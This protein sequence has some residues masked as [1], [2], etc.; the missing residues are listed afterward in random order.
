[1]TN[2]TIHMTRNDFIRT[3]QGNGFVVYAQDGA[4]PEWAVALRTVVKA[5]LPNGNDLTETEVVHWTH[6]E[7]WRGDKANTGLVEY[8][9]SLLP[10]K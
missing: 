4:H 10:T 2:R 3:M 9:N 6:D 8:E 7:G 1:M 5:T